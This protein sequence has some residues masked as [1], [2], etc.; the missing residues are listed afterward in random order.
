[1]AQRIGRGE[2]LFGRVQR[3]FERRRGGGLHQ[4]TRIFRTN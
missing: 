3:G 2:S 1:M 4:F